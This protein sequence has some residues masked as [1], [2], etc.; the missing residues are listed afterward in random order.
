[1]YEI[2]DKLLIL[3]CCTTLYLSEYRSSFFIVPLIVV[4]VL[5]SLFQYF[6]N[7]NIKLTG[8]ILFAALCFYYPFL[9]IFF[10]LILYDIFNTR[11]QY[12]AIL[13]PFLFINNYH[14][15]S[16]I[17]LSFS[18]LF[19]LVSYYLKCRTNRMHLLSSEYNE[20]R[21]NSTQ[22]SLLLKEKNQSLLQN[23]DYEVHLA[24]LNER[25]RISKEIHDNIGHLLSRA[26]LQ[27]GAL[28]TLTSENLI[29][30]GLCSLKT[31]LSE[32][33]DQVRNSI[34]N[35]Y[36]ESIDL[37]TQVNDLVKDFSF[38]T[39]N[40][41]YDIKNQPSISMKH[42]FIA[43]IK[44]SLTNIMHHSNATKASIILRE[45]PVM[46]QLII[47]DNGT[48]EEQTKQTLLKAYENSNYGEGMGIRNIT[49][50]VKGYRGNIH[51]TL[52]H[53]YRLFISIPKQPQD[54]N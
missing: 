29:K 22:I 53:G 54:K 9:L 28:T 36:E 52:D 1:M 39:V 42:S 46:Y 23:Q 30:D 19:F 13:I 18:I 7:D 26:I 45:H 21:D 47:H 37:F 49:E 40:F 33:M 35:M 14:D 8:S 34:H 27:V 32:G 10:P 3:L 4:I 5:S 16:I 15:L 44:E 41:E 20:L 2:T 43:I 24:T 12:A 38:C 17:S 6:E 11:Y 25:N 51:I 50:R 48:L 31:S